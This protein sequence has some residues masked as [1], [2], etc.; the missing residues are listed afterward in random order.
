MPPLSEKAYTA[1]R[2]ARERRK[3]AQSPE[4]RQAAALAR[5][6]ADPG[7]PT[8]W[9]QYALSCP[10]HRA[11]TRTRRPCAQ[12]KK[13]KVLPLV[14]PLSIGQSALPDLFGPQSVAEQTAKVE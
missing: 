8:L 4:A 10:S 6:Q 2:V 5:V 11:L 1:I 14:S 7:D 13:A 9:A 12:G 3:R